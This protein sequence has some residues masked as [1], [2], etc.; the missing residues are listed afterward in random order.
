MERK[1]VVV[2]AGGVGKSAVTIQFMQGTFTT[3]YDP[4]IEDSYRKQ[5]EVDN[6]HLILDILDTA[7]QEE[8]SSMRAAYMRSGHG[9]ICVYSIVSENSV[10]ELKSIRQTML[11][12][13]NSDAVPMV[14]LGN[15]CDLKEERVVEE[16]EG[17][18]L[19]EE[20]GCPFFETSAK[21]NINIVEAFHQVA[22]E[23]IAANTDD[24]MGGTVAAG[25]TKAGKPKKSGCYLL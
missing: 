15:K 25:T 20:Y 24:T 4:T 5:I 6:L 16:Q 2:G 11:R 19:A 3:Q 8:Y 18:D 23:I 1:V 21:E 22:R 9:F 17:K 14:L 7:G 10:K 13:K 12:A